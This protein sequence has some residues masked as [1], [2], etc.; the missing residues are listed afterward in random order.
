MVARDNGQNEHGSTHLD[1]HA[2]TISLDLR[3]RQDVDHT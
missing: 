3:T 1:D 2:S